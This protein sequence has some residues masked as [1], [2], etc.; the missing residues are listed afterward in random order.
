MKNLF[1]WLPLFIFTSCY[2]ITHGKF[3]NDI[4]VKTV[5]FSFDDGPNAYEDNTVRLLDVLKKH[6]V[7]AV[8]A[9]IGENAEAYPEIVRR[10][11]EEGHF[12][13]N[14]GYSGKLNNLMRRLE[15]RN[16]LV[17]GG[18]A[19]NNALGFEL[20]PKYYRP[21]GGFYYYW[22]KKI[23][24]EE[25]YHILP[26]NIRV[27]DAVISGRNS[28]N[29]VNRIIRGVNKNRGGFLL[30]HDARDSHFSMEKQL[31]RHPDGM[32]NRSWIPDVVEELIE[33]LIDRGYTIGDP[34]DFI[35]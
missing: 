12:I 20:L 2:S 13:V 31:T 30:L 16:N 21:H 29:I 15:F 32:F 24:I 22:Q 19:I 1:L 5:F 23:C 3:D 27:Y 7:R 4:P 26:G 6:N 28:G 25:G 35:H 8:F 14:H 10:I 17:M 33:L 18:Q 11:Y 34:H 9:L